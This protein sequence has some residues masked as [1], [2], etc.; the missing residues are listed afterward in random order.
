MKYLILFCCIGIA[1]LFFLLPRLTTRKVMKRFSGTLFAH[2][3]Y[4]CVEKGVPENSMPA[5]QAAIARGYGI[6]LDVHLTKDGQ[7]IVFHDDTLD[8][9]CGV[10]GTP[11]TMTWAELSRLSL[12]GTAYR[13]PLLSDV[14]ALVDGRVPLLIELKIPTSALS[15]CRV[16]L[17]LLEAYE[18]DF[19]V[20]SFHTMGLLWFRLHAPHIL[21]GQL[22]CRFNSPQ[23][24]H[25]PILR[26]L[27]RHLLCNF[28][29]RPDFV[30]YKMAH[31]P[32]VSV[33]ILRKLFH[34]PVAVWTLRTSQA[35]AYGRR[36][37]DMQIFEVPAGEYLFLS[38]KYEETMK[39]S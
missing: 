28:L 38:E 4:H 26:F 5:F 7:L 22:S 12:S 3:G 19:F 37:F 23:D 14:L 13:I 31:L 20:Q 6:E 30:A 27:V 21:R 9:I 15:I 39:K 1:Y 25:S 11:E 17:P 2:R 36:H 34:L 16:C 8:R 35:L 18:G 29:G 10:S 24:E 32:S 33:G